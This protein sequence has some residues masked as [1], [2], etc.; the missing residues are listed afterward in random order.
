MTFYFGKD[1]PGIQYFFFKTKT[2]ELA[3][4]LDFLY[5]WDTLF[6][7]TF[8]VTFLGLFHLMNNRGRF[9]TVPK[10]WHGV[11]QKMIEGLF[12]KWEN[13]LIEWLNFKIKNQKFHKTTYRV[14]FIHS[15]TFLLY[16]TLQK[17]GQKINVNII[18]TALRRSNF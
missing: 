17:L 13:R 11:M 7:Y 9:F 1:H 15:K 3:N 10:I 2:M 4:V 8:K 5:F 14:Q 16:T 12:D 18:K 6:L